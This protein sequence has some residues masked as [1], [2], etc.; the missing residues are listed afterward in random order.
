MLEMHP[1]S[2]EDSLAPAQGKPPK[3]YHYSTIPNIINLW[4]QVLGFPFTNIFA[5]YSKQILLQKLS[6][7]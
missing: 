5:H 6:G 1:I 7:S 2:L 4:E 3:D